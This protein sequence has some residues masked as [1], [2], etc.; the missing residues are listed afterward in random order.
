MKGFR[1]SYV[2]KII[3]KGRANQVK[4]SKRE[5]KKKGRRKTKNRKDL[6]KR[7]WKEQKKRYQI[8]V[9]KF[10]QYKTQ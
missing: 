3:K 5:N 6:K 4:E 10:T 2:I 9:L 7:R 1:E 8:F